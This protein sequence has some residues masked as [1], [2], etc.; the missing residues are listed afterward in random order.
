GE[1]GGGGGRAG[2]GAARIGGG[3]HLEGGGRGERGGSSRQQ[4]LSDARL[5]RRF[6]PWSERSRAWSVLSP[7]GSPIMPY[8][9]GST[10]LCGRNRGLCRFRQSLFAASAAAE[11]GRRIPCR[12]G[13]DQRVN[14]DEH[15]GN[16]LVSAVHRR[17]RRCR[18]A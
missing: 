8:G 6:E 3:Q 12:P 5:T 13:R 10:E 11:T 7:G 1:W 15:C 14:D 4:C 9:F 17:A 16:C 2:D 18:G